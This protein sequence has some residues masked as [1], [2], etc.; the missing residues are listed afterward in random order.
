VGEVFMVRFPLQILHEKMPRLATLTL[1]FLK[2]ILCFL[3]NIF[4]SGFLSL[5]SENRFPPMILSYPL[6][7]IFFY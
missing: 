4:T 3:E 6:V 2:H 5:T 7:Q 1:L